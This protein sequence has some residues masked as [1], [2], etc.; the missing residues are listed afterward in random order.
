MTTRHLGWGR[1]MRRLIL[2]FA[3][4]LMTYCV[5]YFISGAR[6]LDFGNGNSGLTVVSTLSTPLPGG[7]TVLTGLSSSRFF[8]SSSS[9]T[10]RWSQQEPLVDTEHKTIEEL[11]LEAAATIRN[12]PAP[13]YILPTY[14]QGP[15]FY[16]NS[17][18][19]RF[20]TIY[21]LEFSNTYWQAWV[22]IQFSR[23][24]VKFTH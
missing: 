3:W 18:C 14:K 20:P 2:L 16:R 24:C 7:V 9:T 6:V 4:L 15:K 19:A 10:P 11:I 1:P 5:F 17:S 13:P 22:V 12:I 23:L 8:S 21:D